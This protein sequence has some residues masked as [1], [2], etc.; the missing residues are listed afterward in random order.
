M[1]L[2]INAYKVCMS[3]ESSIRGRFSDKAYTDFAAEV[4][5]THPPRVTIR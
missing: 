4:H 1:N 3:Q 2:T 5:P